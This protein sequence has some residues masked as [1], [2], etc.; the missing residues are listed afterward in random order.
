MKRAGPALGAIVVAIVV[1]AAVFAL[2]PRSEPAV[3]GLQAVG[4]RPFGDGESVAV[5]TSTAVLGE[6]GRLAV[7][8]GGRLGVARGGRV[9]PVTDDGS[10]VV[11]VAWFAD[12]ATLLVAEGPVPTGTLAVVQID[13]MVRGSIPLAPSVGFG[14]GYGMDVAPGGRRAV[15]TAVERP[16][17]SGEQRHLV[18]VDLEAGTTRPLTEPGAAPQETGPHVL[19]DGRVAFTE[20]DDAGRERP[21]LLD[22]ASGTVRQVAPAGSVVGTAGSFVLVLVERELSAVPA[23]GASGERAVLGRVPAGTALTSVD[24][25]RGEA[26]VVDRQGRV[27]RLQIESVPA[28]R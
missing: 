18:L 7:V 25:R 6:G 3:D 17:L 24:A 10:R 13:G 4:D 11:D 23:P 12:G 1:M 5:D 20:I 27:Q 26:V 14:A 19:D 9:R 15:V 28:G 16:A 2:V 8:S 21:R 22:P